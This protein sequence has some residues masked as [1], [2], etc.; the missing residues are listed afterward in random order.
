M[1]GSQFAEEAV[2]ER[3]LSARSCTKN[4]PDTGAKAESGQQHG[5]PARQSQ[6]PKGAF[7]ILVLKWYNQNE[8]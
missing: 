1:T 7:F 6:A 4:S 2:R 3:A 8:R 5:G